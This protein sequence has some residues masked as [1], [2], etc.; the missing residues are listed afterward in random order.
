MGRLANS[1]R[2]G[3]RLA[4]DSRDVRGGAGAIGAGGVEASIHTSRVNR[5]VSN[6][7]N[8]TDLR[9][10]LGNVGSKLGN[11]GS[12][13]P[14]LAKQATIGTGTACFKHKPTC[15]LLTG[16]LVYTGQKLSEEKTACMKLCMPSNWT[17]YKKDSEPLKYNS[18]DS[19]KGKVD[20]WP[21]DFNPAFCSS[22]SVE[23][24]KKY[25]GDK[26]S[27]D[28]GTVISATEH[29]AQGAVSFLERAGNAVEN[30]PQYIMYIFL[31]ISV[32]FI[33][34]IVLFHNDGAS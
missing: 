33:L 14:S 9:T 27:I 32:V 22:G 11:V 19:L 29:T 2:A 6:L 24:C 17:T 23:D 15:L 30:A 18:K 28:A 1:V 10:I 20:D 7:K 12:K 34:Y 25:C 3:M 4:D 5:Q 21:E 26:C 13:V 31:G 16:G 8:S